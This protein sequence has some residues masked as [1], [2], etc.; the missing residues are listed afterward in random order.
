MESQVPDLNSRLLLGLSP[1]TTLVSFY[2]CLGW[3]GPKMSIC[4]ICF[5]EKVGKGKQRGVYFAAISQAR[6][7]YQEFTSLSHEKLSGKKPLQDA[8]IFLCRGWGWEGRKKSERKESKRE[9]RMSFHL[10]YQKNHS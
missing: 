1:F 10:H 8:A 6:L 7:E 5:S 2:L 9:P 4:F 3:D